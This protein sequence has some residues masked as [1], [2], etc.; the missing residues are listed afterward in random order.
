MPANPF[1]TNVAS[2]T[3]LALGI[4][5]VVPADAD[6]ETVIREIRVGTAPDGGGTLRIAGPEGGVVNLVNVQSGDVFAGPF[7]RIYATG[8]TVSDIVGWL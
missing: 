3:G 7:Y 5:A 6:L 8:T 4:I 1:A 2:P